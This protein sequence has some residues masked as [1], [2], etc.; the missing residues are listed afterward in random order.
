MKFIFFHILLLFGVSFF[1]FFLG[2]YDEPLAKVL[3]HSGFFEHLSDSDNKTW[4]EIH[5]VDVTPFFNRSLVQDIAK[6]LV[7]LLRYV[8]Y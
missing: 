6:P 3:L 8:C 4:K 2:I 7:N 1:L 5:L